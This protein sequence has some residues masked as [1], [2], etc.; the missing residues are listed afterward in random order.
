M[1]TPIWT[2]DINGLIRAREVTLEDCEVPSTWDVRSGDRVV[3]AAT[4]TTYVRLGKEAVENL[5]EVWDPS[6][7]WRDYRISNDTTYIFERYIRI[8]VPVSFR[9]KHKPETIDKKWQDAVTKVRASIQETGESRISA[10]LADIN[11]SIQ[12]HIERRNYNIIYG[13]VDKYT[14]SY[15]FSDI[16]QAYDEVTQGNEECR[17]FDAELKTLWE[18]EKELKAKRLNL[19]NSLLRKM[20]ENETCVE[21]KEAILK[22]MDTKEG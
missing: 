10:A 4:G 7:L 20:L 19:Y 8:E 9:G 21:I 16:P 15:P 1:K 17:A 11:T 6:N 3:S 2:K 13:I 18:K 22:A 12:N 14:K 5:K